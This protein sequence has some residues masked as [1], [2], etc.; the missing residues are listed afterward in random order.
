MSGAS[1]PVV[2]VISGPEKLDESHLLEVC[3]KGVIPRS[4]NAEYTGDFALGSLIVSCSDIYELWNGLQVASV[5]SQIDSILA[6][7]AK[8]RTRTGPQCIHS[9]YS[10]LCGQFMCRHFASFVSQ[11]NL[12]S[13]LNTKFNVNSDFIAVDNAYVNCYMSNWLDIFVTLQTIASNVTDNFIPSVAEYSIIVKE[14]SKHPLWVQVMLE[15]TVA[16]R[17]GPLRDIT[18]R[19]NVQNIGWFMNQI[20]LTTSVDLL[21]KLFTSPSVMGKCAAIYSLL[22]I[23]GQLWKSTDFSLIESIVPTLYTIIAWIFDKCKLAGTKAGDSW[24]WVKARFRRGPNE[25]ELYPQAGSKVPDVPTDVVTPESASSEPEFT[26]Q[27]FENWYKKNILHEITAQISNSNNCFFEAVAEF[28]PGRTAIEI[29]QEAFNY[30]NDN[31]KEIFDALILHGF[32]EK[33]ANAEIDGLI[34]DLNEGRMLSATMLLVAQRAFKIRLSCYEIREGKAICTVDATYS[35]KTSPPFF[36]KNQDHIHWISSIEPI[37]FERNFYNLL[38]VEQEFKWTVPEKPKTPTPPSSKPS[39]TT[40]EK[41]PSFSTM[42]TPEEPKLVAEIEATEAETAEVVKELESTE[43]GRSFMDWF[44]DLVGDVYTFFKNN[45]I[46]GGIMAFAYSVMSGIGIGIGKF[47][48]QFDKRSFWEK[49]SS[50]S[51]DFYYLSRGQD[52]VAKVFGDFGEIFRSMMGID[53]NPAVTTFKQ[54]L[55]DICD[56]AEAMNETCVNNPEIIS[57]DPQKLLEFKREMENIS[58]QYRDL[59]RLDPTVNLQV[60]TPLWTRLNQTYQHL[61]THYGKLCNNKNSRQR[62]YCLWLYGVSNIGKS[63]IVDHIIRE[64]NLANGTAWDKFTVST[65]PEYLNGFKQERIILVDDFDSFVTQEGCLDAM[66]VMNM[67]TCAAYNP[68]MAHLDD[69]NLQAKPALVIIVSNFATARLNSG[70]NSFEAFER[71]RDR[72]IRVTWPEHEGCAVNAKCSH[73]K[74]LE[75]QLVN[76]GEK[77]FEHL[78]FYDEDTMVISHND[79]KGKKTPMGKNSSAP[80]PPNKGF[81][82][83][84]ISF[85]DI[86]DDLVERIKYYRLSYEATERAHNRF[87]QQHAERMKSSEVKPEAADVV[88]NGVNQSISDWESRPNIM[89]TGPPGTG[90][91]F[92][93][94]EI[95][96]RLKR[97]KKTFKRV[98]TISDFDAGAASEWFYGKD[99]TTVLFD[100]FSTFKDSLHL[101]KFIKAWKE[102]YDNNDPKIATWI[103]G[104]NED[105]AIDKFSTLQEY[106]VFSRRCH[107]F[108]FTFKYFRE[109]RN[110][111]IAK[112]YQPQDLKK[113]SDKDPHSNYVEITDTLKDLKWIQ[114]TLA[115]HLSAWVPTVFEHVQQTALPLFTQL[116]VECIATVQASTEE[117]VEMVNSKGTTVTAMNMLLGEFQS[118]KFTKY[119]IGKRIWKSFNSLSHAHGS[120]FPNMDEFVITGVNNGF[121]SNFKD[122][123]FVMKFRDKSYCLVPRNGEVMAGIWAPVDIVKD[124][125][126]LK[127]VMRSA[128]TTVDFLSVSHSQLPPWF[129]L[130][131]S[132]AEQ[133]LKICAASAV[134]AHN[135]HTRNL[136]NKMLRL[137]QE[138]E[139]NQDKYVDQSLQGV[140]TKH[141][142][143][144]IENEF[145]NPTPLVTESHSDSSDSKSSKKPQTLRARRIFSKHAKNKW[146][147]NGTVRLAIVKESAVRDD[148]KEACIAI[149]EDHPK[150]TAIAQLAT[151]NGL[152]DVV[153]S[154][155]KNFVSICDLNGKHLV[156]ALMIKGVWG[157]TVNHLFLQYNPSQLQVKTIDGSKYQLKLKKQAA[158]EDRADFELTNYKQTF[159]DITRHLHH[160]TTSSFTNKLGCLVHVD[161]TD[162]LP[163]LT[164]RF[165]RIREN[166]VVTLANCYQVM[167]WKYQG[168]ISG[169]STELPPQTRAGDCGSVMFL[170]DKG[171]Q[172]KII[173]MHIASSAVEGFFRQLR[174]IDY[175]DVG[176]TQ[177]SA[178]MG[179]G[180]LGEFIPP[181]YE[182][183]REGTPVCGKCTKPPH[184]P[185]KTTLYKSPFQFG[186]CEYEPSVLDKKDHRRPDIDDMI[187][188][189]AKKWTRVVPVMPEAQVEIVRRRMYEIGDWIGQ[190]INIF[191]I[192]TFLLNKT[193]ALNSVRGFTHSQPIPVGTSAGYPFNCVVSNGKRQ[194]IETLEDGSR[195][196]SLTNHNVKY[197]HN[198][199]D[200]VL[201]A[202][203]E[204]KLADVAFLVFG[205]DELLKPGKNTR[206]IAAAPLPLVIAIRMYFH[207]IYAAI[208]EIWNLIPIKVGI[209]PNQMDWNTLAR[210]FLNISNVGFAIDQKG[211]DFNIPRPIVEAVGEALIAI[212]IDTNPD[213]TVEQIQ[214]MRNLHNNVANFKL[215]IDGLVYQSTIGVP[216]G[217]P[218]TSIENSIISF[219]LLYDSFCEL[220]PQYV[221]RN[222]DIFSEC[223][224][225]AIYGDD[226]TCTVTPSVLEW[227]NQVSVTKY[228][229]QKYN[230]TITNADKT[231]KIRPYYPL[232]EMEF[233]SRSFV[234]MDGYWVGPLSLK[235]LAKPLHFCHGNRAHHWYEEPDKLTDSVENAC[236]AARS[237]LDEMFFHGRK[238]Y[239]ELRKHCL[240]VVSKLGVV[241]AYFPTWHARHAEFFETE[242]N[243]NAALQVFVIPTDRS[244]I[245]IIQQ[246]K[247]WI[248]YSNRRCI[249]FGVNYFW[250]QKS[251]E[252]Q[253][254]PIPYELAVILNKVNKMLNTNFNQILVN[255]YAKGGSIPLHKDNEKGLDVEH[256]V[257]SL[258]VTGD[259][260]VEWINTRNERKGIVQCQPDLL[261]Y[262]KNEYVKEYRHTRHSH[263][264]YTISLTFRRILEQ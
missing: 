107:E 73:R 43:M 172:Q 250:D 233:L 76:T 185:S 120:H 159:P 220:A 183:D 46:I 204:G 209:A 139:Q 80:I 200:S 147:S 69:K 128:V 182:K 98:Q 260:V 82:P 150:N 47:T 5:S 155:I 75:Q 56:R 206:T 143:A 21:H 240:D 254:L 247:P 55:V 127:G 225:A 179:Q 106:S 221:V 251:S 171:S 237:A 174:D 199:I 262:M 110:L 226:V 48:N 4:Y 136:S 113:I 86:I 72:L 6:V 256:G 30:L 167:A 49:V 216:S 66:L 242:P 13:L 112:S 157:T 90:K 10:I 210:S 193:T 165:Y 234:K 93:L 105:V 239:E 121:F 44:R 57:N 115:G 97:N 7:A 245:P 8:H 212:A 64:F 162:Q 166:A 148:V 202:S 177:C 53:D 61:L 59:I 17:C 186:E 108:K 19:V 227:F 60:L 218:G 201:R 191:G 131:V 257:A 134:I 264:R 222:V 151:D 33:D 65:G 213:L 79:Y 63:E 215:I 184:V 133:V 232:T 187:Y 24:K 74:A 31:R 224:C 248:T 249:N 35:D 26:V 258:T 144:L 180:I 228:L 109:F 125:A 78:H 211:F 103:L 77:T 168:G 236:A 205:K 160:Q 87:L 195:R 145:I 88:D 22:E 119:D 102:R 11:A 54:N 18:A 45:P 117:F 111:Y 229:T 178:Q 104:I 99:Y 138:M 207:T 153:R 158:D 142:D 51:K 132:I 71:R 196:F 223:V 101:A 170:C 176:I 28:L 252:N 62:P 95:G 96:N 52:A 192:R 259:G 152:H 14:I 129:V 39:S 217:H 122:G 135:I 3:K 2:K 92:C 12:V 181:F 16:L 116:D 214:V 203:R 27:C 194:L 149:S 243:N 36:I 100:D 94:T 32:E 189:E 70:I 91:S 231:D 154:T 161:L 238:K 197:L 68:N 263:S 261:Y 173:G 37:N 81:E 255:A 83:K 219:F 23:H 114:S 124:M 15:E 25:Q 123:N 175:I 89:L 40:D 84:E 169:F 67:V 140:S 241:E 246:S 85:Q 20:K 163:I 188:Q 146:E 141:K 29:R 118:E 9:V 208:S 130:S 34:S 235:R 164:M 126:K 230:L 190:K 156:H 137:H 1:K 198:A 38:G 42:S 41:T 50:C 253:P 244:V 58:K